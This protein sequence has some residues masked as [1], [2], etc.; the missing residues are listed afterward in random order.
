[1]LEHVTTAIMRER[2]HVA[3][4]PERI[5]ALKSLVVSG[6]KPC[7]PACME[8]ESFC[9]TVRLRFAPWA[10][11]PQVKNKQRKSFQEKSNKT[12]NDKNGF[13]CFNYRQQSPLL[14]EQRLAHNEQ[15]Q[16]R[17]TNKVKSAI[18]L[19][20]FQSLAP[21]DCFKTIEWCLSGFF[22]ALEYSSLT[23]KCWLFN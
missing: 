7:R 1:M 20:L 21:F 22:R 13:F 17:S 23:L 11:W 2:V 4:V 9:A 10:L 16:S 8:G 19:F 12:M 5:A 15:V 6:F 3:G 18:K 14:L